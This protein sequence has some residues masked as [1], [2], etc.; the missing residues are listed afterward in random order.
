MLGSVRRIWFHK[1]LV[2]SKNNDD[3]QY[4]WESAADGSFTVPKD[5]EVVR[6][7]RRSFTA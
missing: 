2:V 7:A 6:E 1:V 3:E 5:T 4:A